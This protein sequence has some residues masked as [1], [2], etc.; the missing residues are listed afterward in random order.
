MVEGV[1]KAQRAGMKVSVIALLGLGGA[2]LSDQHA[3]ETG[4][5]VSAMDPPYLSLLTL[6]LIPGTE[7]HRQ[8]ES[9]TFQLMKPEDLLG[10]MRQVITHLEGLSRC[11]FRTNHASNYLP[12]AG[13]LSRDKA[14][15]LATL[16]QALAE[17]PS[18]LRPEEWRAL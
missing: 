14:R 15:L 18:R 16:D 17:G 5:V 13:T 8:W 4:R 6:M 3:E 11:I 9:G 2:D 12:L 7:L 10:E 1:Q